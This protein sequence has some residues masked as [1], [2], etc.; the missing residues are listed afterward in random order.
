MSSEVVQTEQR[1][2]NLEAIT[3]SGLPRTR[4]SSTPRTRCQPAGRRPMAAKT[5]AELESPKVE[6][7][8]AGRVVGIRSFGKA[9]FLVLSDGRSRLQV[10]VRQDALSERDYQLLEAAR[11]RRPDR[12]GRT[13]VPHQDQRAVDLGVAAGVSRQVLPAAA[14][15][16]ARPAGRRDPLPPALSRPRSSIR[17]CAACSR[18]ARAADRGDSRFPDEPRLPRSRDADDAADRRRRA[19]AAVRDASQHARHEA[20]PAHRA[21]ALPQ[22]AH[23]RRHRTRLRDQ[24]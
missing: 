22:A 3:A 18:F 20:V 21:G 15:E 19:G 4:I 10:Y 1:K 5:A 17:T 7:V 6:T 16:V 8:T 23:G 24:S 13:S 12:R 14:G 9:S 11:C 2:A